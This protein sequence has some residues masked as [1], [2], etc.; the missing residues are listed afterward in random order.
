MKAV[1][2]PHLLHPS[3]T[4]TLLTRTKLTLSNL[5]RSPKSAN[6]LGDSISFSNGIL[7]QLQWRLPTAC[8]VQTHFCILT[9]FPDKI[10]MYFKSLR[11]KLYQ[12][13]GPLSPVSQ[14]AC[15]SS[16]NG[17]TGHPERFRQAF[18]NSMTSSRCRGSWTHMPAWIY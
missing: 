18:I 16:A 3:L 9:R 5:A 15:S 7:V 12:P 10:G 6:I 1:A 8:A 2:R 13:C 4:R 14:K 17:L 11:T